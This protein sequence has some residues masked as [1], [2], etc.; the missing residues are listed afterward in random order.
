M[1]AHQLEQKVKNL[2]FEKTNPY[3]FFEK[4]EEECT[5]ITEEAKGAHLKTLYIKN[6]PVHEH[7]RA[8]W[9]INL[10]KHIP[11]FNKTSS[12]TVESA[13]LMVEPKK[14]TF[15]LIEFKS[16]ISH[17]AKPP[18]QSTLKSIHDKLND[19][20][21]RIHFLFPF[22]EKLLEQKELSHRIRF[23]GLVFYIK[24]TH[25]D[26][27]EEGRLYEII[28]AKN[29]QGL[30]LCNTIFGDYKIKVKF[31]SNSNEE[32]EIDFIKLISIL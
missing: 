5:S 11:G 26:C 9:K 22:L 1:E 4:I 18:K 30:L 25:T 32:T 19:T 17:K 24:R 8:F 29:S 12:K 20:I 16:S 7:Q 28:S 31:F 10:E 2:L 15:F 23:V 6:I 14:I 21:S 27:I 13:L 3:Q